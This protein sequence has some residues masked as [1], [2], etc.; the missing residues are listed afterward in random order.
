MIILGRINALILKQS[1]QIRVIG[2]KLKESIF[3]PTLKF[4]YGSVERIPGEK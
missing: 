2:G 3:V 1:V 4:N